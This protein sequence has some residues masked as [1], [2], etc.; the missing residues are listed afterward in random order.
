V[1]NKPCLAFLFLFGSRGLLPTAHPY[2]LSFLTSYIVSAK[3]WEI[4]DVGNR[5]RETVDDMI[6]DLLE[7]ALLWFSLLLS[8]FLCEETF[9]CFGLVASMFLKSVALTTL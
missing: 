6:R 9:R 1:V 8:S 4:D 2:I 5:R 7:I 3:T